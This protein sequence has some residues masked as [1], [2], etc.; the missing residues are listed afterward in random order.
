MHN[1]HWVWAHIEMS[2]KRASCTGVSTFPRNQ[3][4]NSCVREFCA[5][6]DVTCQHADTKRQLSRIL[7]ALLQ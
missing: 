1:S 3:N 2:S 7:T 5:Q 4:W 6:V